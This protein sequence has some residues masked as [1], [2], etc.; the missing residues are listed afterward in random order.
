MKICTICKDE[1]KPD[2]FNKNKR[3][4]DGLNTICKT[5]SRENSKKYYS[6][7]KEYHI[8]E[9]NKRKLRMQKENRLNVFEYYKTHPCIDCGNDNP[10]IL[11]FDHRDGE[12]KLYNVADMVRAPMS[13]ANIEVEIAKCDVRCANCHRIRTAIQL[14]W[15]NKIK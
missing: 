10:I 1:K 4:K 7:N 13:W 11:E 5:C 2:D 6:E 12:K 9:I 15:Y 3:E 14:G 8:S